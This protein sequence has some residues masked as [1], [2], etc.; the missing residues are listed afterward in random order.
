MNIRLREQVLEIEGVAEKGGA[1]ALARREGYGS[2][3]DQIWRHGSHPAPRQEDSE[4]CEPPLAARHQQD[5]RGEDVAGEHEEDL[6]AEDRD[7]FGDGAVA[8]A[9]HEE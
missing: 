5:L 3:R 6:D 2:Q 7:G 8:A 4:V 1:K 9:Q